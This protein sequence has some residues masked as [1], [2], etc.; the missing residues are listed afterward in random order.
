MKLSSQ[1]KTEVP[2][3]LNANVF[4]IFE[5]HPIYDQTQAS[6]VVLFSLLYR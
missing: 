4:H 2:T 5:S 1:E 3:P 6:S